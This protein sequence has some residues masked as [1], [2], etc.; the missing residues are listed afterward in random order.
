MTQAALRVAIVLMGAYALIILTL[1][2]A[3]FLR[4]RRWKKKAQLTA[5]LLPEIRAS[6]VN[7]LS[8]SDDLAPLRRSLEI[9][10]G[11]V[12]SVILGLQDSVAG[13]ARDRLCAL[14][15]ELELLHEWRGG[16]RSR[17][18]TRRRAAFAGI[19]FASAYDPC[20]RA[21]G[22]ILVD[23]IE[24]PD[25][26]VRVCVAQ[27]VAQFG[28][29]AEI[30]LVFRMAA[31]ANLLTR[32]L[33]AGSLR[34][35]ALE[36]SRKAVPEELHSADE[37]RILATLELVV[38]WERALPLAGLDEM[39]RYPNRAIRIQALRA[40]PLVIASPENESAVMEALAD[41]DPEVAMAAAAVVG[42]LQIA[43]ALP[44]LAQCCRSGN[45]ALI[46]TAV[47]S[48]LA[49]APQGWNALEEL[50]VSEDP[51]IA[52]AAA[53]ALVHVRKARG[54]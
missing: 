53:E 50:A 7:Y 48:M 52:A 14:T 44:L 42:R 5:A 22:D 34:P 21:V 36:L 16:I 39:I 12:S 2:G 3:A 25:P 18:V 9:S 54:G 51:T 28:S 19:A 33:V 46:R 47:A 15:L 23:A 10:R 38:A 11:D 37:P 13:T 26:E 31:R 49:L 8:G 35:H 17:D 24:D 32:V 45:P 1:F 20:R 6:L 27:A 4:G 40:V 41:P 29:P 43:A 30:E